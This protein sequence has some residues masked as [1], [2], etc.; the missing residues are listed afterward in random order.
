[1]F[2]LRNSTCF[3]VFPLKIEAPLQQKH[4]FCQI[5]SD[6]FCF[7][8]LGVFPP[9]LLGSLGLQSGSYSGTLWDN[10]LVHQDY[11]CADMN[12]T[13]SLNNSKLTA[14]EIYYQGRT[15]RCN[16]FKQQTESILCTKYGLRHRT[17]S[18]EKVQKFKVDCITGSSNTT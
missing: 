11:I 5:S 2:C 12:S 18:K 10:L 1:V 6:F 13:V 16:N 17:F 14:S 3:I 9:E 7:F 4:Y 15:P 8:C